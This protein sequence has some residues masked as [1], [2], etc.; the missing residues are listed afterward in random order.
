MRPAPDDRRLGRN[1]QIFDPVTGVTD[2]LVECER[3]PND[4][5]LGNLADHR[6]GHHQLPREAGEAPG[7]RRILANGD[8]RRRA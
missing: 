2:P 3:V 5:D 1:N 8:A 4:Q 6:L 7:E